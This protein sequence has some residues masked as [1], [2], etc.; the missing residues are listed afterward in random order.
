[1]HAG[2]QLLAGD[3]ELTTRLSN[4]RHIIDGACVFEAKKRRDRIHYTSFAPSQQVRLASAAVSS[5]NLGVSCSSNDSDESQRAW[6]RSNLSCPS[7]RWLSAVDLQPW[8]SNSCVDEPKHESPG[9]PVELLDSCYT[10]TPSSTPYL[11]VT[12]LL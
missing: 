9:L 4:S 8:S 5:S 10:S 1:M 7:H 12:L 6:W 2:N 11:A 3:P